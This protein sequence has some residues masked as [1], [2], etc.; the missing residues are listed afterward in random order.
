MQPVMPRLLG[1]AVE[2]HEPRVRFQHATRFLESRERVGQVMM[3]EGAGGR[4]QK[5]RSQTGSPRRAR[6][7]M[8]S[9]APFSF[10]R[11]SIVAE[12]SSPQ[13]GTPA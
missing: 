12:S 5:R 7:A 9:Q 3:H 11:L 4:R 10:A 8:R 6:D 13:T 1:C 2:N